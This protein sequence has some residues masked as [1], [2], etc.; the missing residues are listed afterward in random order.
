MMPRNGLHAAMGSAINAYKSR[1]ASSLG[2]VTSKYMPHLPEL[3]LEAAA[4]FLT[5]AAPTIR[6]VGAGLGMD[7]LLA[8]AMDRG[9][10]APMLLHI[11]DGLTVS[12]W[13]LN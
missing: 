1:S 6:A 12:T 9:R 4:R 7:R 2:D 11:S 3:G 10:G 13:P 8:R 5:E